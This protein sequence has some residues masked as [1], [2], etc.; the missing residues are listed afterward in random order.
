[1]TETID[2]TGYTITPYLRFDEVDGASILHQRWDNPHSNDGRPPQLWV[3]VPGTGS[4]AGARGP[5]GAKGDP[6][7]RGPR[8]AHG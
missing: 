5:K 2:L 1:M 4:G 6:G 8:G 3:A 7:E